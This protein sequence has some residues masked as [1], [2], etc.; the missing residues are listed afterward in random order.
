M[1][2]NPHNAQFQFVKT[3]KFF[4]YSI[5]PVKY[6]T[7]VTQIRIYWLFYNAS[8]SRKRIYDIYH[9]GFNY[10]NRSYGQCEVLGYKYTETSRFMR[11]RVQYQFTRNTNHSS[12]R[13]SGQNGKKI[14]QKM[15]K[16]GFL[17][18]LKSG[19]NLMLQSPR[20]SNRL[21]NGQQM[22]TEVVKFERMIYT[23]K[24]LDISKDQLIFAKE[25]FYTSPGLFMYTVIPMY[26][27]YCSVGTGHSFLSV[28]ASDLA[29]KSDITLKMQNQVINITG[30]AVKESFPLTLH[31]NVVD[32]KKIIRD[33]DI[34]ILDLCYFEKTWFEYRIPPNN[35]I[36]SNL[37]IKKSY[38]PNSTEAIKVKLLATKV[39]QVVLLL[40]DQAG[41][42]WN[43]L[44]GP[45]DDPFA[46]IDGQFGRSS[47]VTKVDYF[48]GMLVVEYLPKPS[49][50]M[51]QK[52]KKMTVFG[53]CK[54][55]LE[56]VTKNETV[57]EY[58]VLTCVKWFDFVL[59]SRQSTSQAGIVIRPQ[60]AAIFVKNAISSAP[61]NAKPKKN[62]SVVH[63]VQIL[64]FDQKSAKLTTLST[65][66][67]I[68]GDQLAERLQFEV[69]D[70]IGTKIL[71][72]SLQDFEVGKGVAKKV[73]YYQFDPDNAPG[74]VKVDYLDFMDFEEF[75]RS[76][77][78]E[79][80]LDNLINSQS[81]IL[82]NYC[83]PE[84]KSKNRV[85]R[86]AQMSVN[87]RKTTKRGR[88]EVEDPLVLPKNGKIKNSQKELNA[89][90][91]SSVGLRD[92]QPS[93]TETPEETPKIIFYDLNS[94]KISKA[95]VI[96]FLRY[97]SLEPAHDVCYLKSTVFVL[98]VEIIPTKDI[99]KTKEK[100]VLEAFDGTMP[101]IEKQTFPELLELFQ[102]HSFVSS[103]CF[104]KL[105]IYVLVLKSQ[106]DLSQLNLAVLTDN[107]I[108]PRRLIKTVNLEIS[109]ENFEIKISKLDKDH[110]LVIV[111]YPNSNF[112]TQFRIVDIKLNSY[113]VFGNSYGQV[114]T[115][116]LVFNEH[117]NLTQGVEI[118]FRKLPEWGDNK[119][120]HDFFDLDTNI[121]LSSLMYLHAPIYDLEV[122]APELEG[123]KG[124]K[125]PQAAALTI[126]PPVAL[127]STILASPV[128]SQPFTQ[129]SV[130]KDW[131]VGFMI[132]YSPDF[133]TRLV[134]FKNSGEG[135]RAARNLTTR[136]DEC[137][138]VSSAVNSF[139]QI[140]VGM[141]CRHK[142]KM[143][144]R[145]LLLDG[146]VAEGALLGFR[147]IDNWVP[148]KLHVFNGATDLEFILVIKD[149]LEENLNLL[150]LD[151]Q[152]QKMNG[153][154]TQKVYSLS[155]D[156]IGAI[157]QGK[158]QKNIKFTSSTKFSS[159]HM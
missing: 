147:Q 81:L 15:S 141:I 62:G 66:V 96:N 67:R 87:T 23:D 45:E 102:N 16:S 49:E 100:I 77:C 71:V 138:D 51:S 26:G 52:I 72:F 132:D 13:I 107:R 6:K 32:P 90:F 129:S 9:G 112:A 27:T 1:P 145:L 135:S 94:Q 69:I 92:E 85:E 33:C 119:R 113:R 122:L 42:V 38:T 60:F 35:Y 104:N 64:S 24:V 116:M 80:I 151:I 121:D 74:K 109:S 10:Q 11:F 137:S 131:I 108:S 18:R 70:T 7:V 44:N 89:E 57:S 36:G 133:R 98:Q 34:N 17:R 58:I 39:R 149:D 88:R 103:Y 47:R 46:P 93:P 43:E 126:H 2:I 120:I 21:K 22:T 127:N 110:I 143:V 86:V 142:Y 106:M 134:Y 101:S 12:S 99:L 158:S 150:K 124:K 79:K 19:Q 105:D 130:S 78:P 123:K 153:T 159:S 157:Q 28:N 31:L 3:E 4:S 76:F 25:N 91:G 40:L 50:P 29:K 146:T 37:G 54:K 61:N 5:M 20:A 117:D 155:V 111:N 8:L 48:D 30:D 140:L 152:Y 156:Y 128:A 144:V 114:K 65:G 84:A 136:T 139:D 75:E 73:V 83:A 63:E 97:P 115:E 82:F 68:S 148:S 118:E 55:T 154:S 53:K 59:Q 125:R 41:N 56:D 95:S 14:C